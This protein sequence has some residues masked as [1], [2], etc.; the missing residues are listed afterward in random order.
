MQEYIHTILQYHSD[1]KIYFFSGKHHKNLLQP[2]YQPYVVFQYVYYDYTDFRLN[3]KNILKILYVQENNIKNKM[4][5]GINP[6]ILCPKN[7]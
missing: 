2:E 5:F 4:S 6:Y 7:K 1:S 3:V